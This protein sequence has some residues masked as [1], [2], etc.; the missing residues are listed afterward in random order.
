MF[1]LSLQLMKEKERETT[2]GV[3]SILKPML[4]GI[5]MQPIIRWF[6]WLLIGALVATWLNQTVI[7]QCIVIPLTVGFPSLKYFFHSDNCNIKMTFEVRFSHCSFRVF[8]Q[9]RR[10][11]CPLVRCITDVHPV[12]WCGLLSL[13]A[14]RT[15]LFM[16]CIVFCYGFLIVNLLHPVPALRDFFQVSVCVSVCMFVQSILKKK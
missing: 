7:G 14:V 12:P 5:I 1:G 16:L 6:S 9:A 11:E 3:K 8:V 15:D 2:Q 10:T 4:G 13:T